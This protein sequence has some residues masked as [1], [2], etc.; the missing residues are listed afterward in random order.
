M[1][2]GRYIQDATDLNEALAGVGRLRQRKI[3][4]VSARNLSECATVDNMLTM[5]ELVIR[6]ALLR[7]ESRGAH[8][9]TDVRQDWTPADS[10]FGHTWQSLRGSGI[11][12]RGVQR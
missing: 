10:P 1:G 8:V 11:E 3:R 7:E 6:G 4:A 12:K 5:S 2:E 9:R